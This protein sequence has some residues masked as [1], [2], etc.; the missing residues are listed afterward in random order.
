MEKISEWSK[1]CTG[2]RQQQC[3]LMGNQLI[4]KIKCGVTQGRV[5]SPDLFSP[6][7]DITMQSLEGYPR[8]KVGGHNVHNLRYAA[9]VLIRHL[10]RRKQKEKV[11]NE[12]QKDRSNGGQSK[13][14]A[15]KHQHL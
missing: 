1:T 13:Q 10:W 4:K 15:S 2:N 3:R 14:W 7:N 12:E 5:L 8:I 9:A 11:W 6:Y